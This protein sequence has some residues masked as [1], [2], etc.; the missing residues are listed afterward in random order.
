MIL[1]E[2]SLN[3]YLGFDKINQMR[4]KY[5]SKLSNDQKNSF[6]SAAKPR[7]YKTLEEVKQQT[8]GEEKTK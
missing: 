3:K 1:G 8:L 5:I 4:E 6:C 7:S 2:I